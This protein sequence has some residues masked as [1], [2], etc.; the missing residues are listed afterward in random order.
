VCALA[1]P[2]VLVTGVRHVASSSIMRVLA[3]VPI[4]YVVW[5][6]VVIRHELDSIQHLL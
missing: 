4:A 3:V 5:L 1:V 2:F 6:L